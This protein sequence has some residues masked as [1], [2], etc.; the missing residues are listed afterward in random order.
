MDPGISIRLKARSH[1]NMPSIS[2]VCDNLKAQATVHTTQLLA[3]TKELHLFADGINE[4]CVELVK[5]GEIDV[6][7]H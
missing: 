5:K 2:V 3:N 6:S 4:K 1:P 7:H